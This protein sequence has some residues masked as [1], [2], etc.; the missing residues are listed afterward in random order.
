MVA[1]RAYYSETSEDIC[2]Y[3]VC[4]EMRISSSSINVSQI[5]DAQNL[6][7]SAMSVNTLI[8]SVVT[9]R[10]ATQPVHCRWSCV[11]SLAEVKLRTLS[12]LFKNAPQ[13]L[14]LQTELSC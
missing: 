4:L 12:L 6:P 14:N 10:S 13:Y 2:I 7:I 9:G 1:R 11:L 8:M 5:T 3:I